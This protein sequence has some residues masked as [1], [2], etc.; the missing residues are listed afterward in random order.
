MI[1]HCTHH[2]L[3]PITLGLSRSPVKAPAFTALTT[4]KAS[5]TNGSKKT[6]QATPI[7]TDIIN[8]LENVIEKKFSVHPFLS[9]VTKQNALVV[10]R[11]YYAMSQGFPYIQAGAYRNIILSAIQ[12]NQ[13]VSKPYEETFVVG[14]FLSFD[15]T[16]G[17]FLL[18]QKGISALPE[19]LD[20]DKNFH[21]SLLRKDNLA[22]FGKDLE[23]DFSNPTGDYLKQLMTDLGAKD[24]VRRCAAM[25]AFEM[26]AGQMIEALWS[27]ISTI[28][29]TIEKDS[30]EYFK[31]HVGG[32]DPQ[33]EY[34]KLLT[35]RMTSSLIPPGKTAAFL[36]H[37]ERC[38]A[39]NVKWCKDICK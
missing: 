38:Y 17:N 26:H 22:L 27:S 5:Y 34:H 16:G 12:N 9:Q 35:K 25:V 20:T 37:F 1:S 7:N 33:E 21:A 14:A 28:F 19:L 6:F 24:S 13:S 23:P 11:H 18:R 15:E 39:N 8:Q 30:L 31:V 36:K 32:D 3:K 10:M 4:L 29:P 2:L